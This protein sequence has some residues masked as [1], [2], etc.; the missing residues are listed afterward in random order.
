MLQLLDTN[1][2][3]LHPLSKLQRQQLRHVSYVA[4]LLS[5]DKPYKEFHKESHGCH[6]TCDL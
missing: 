4:W 1:A 6:M 3:Q 2:N 5:Q